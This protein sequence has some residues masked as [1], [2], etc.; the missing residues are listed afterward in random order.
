MLYEVAV[1]ALGNVAKHAR[2]T[3]VRVAVSRAGAGWV[4]EVVDDGVGTEVDEH[5]SA[6]FGLRAMRQRAV[7]AGGTLEVDSAPGRGT[8]VRL[9]VPDVA[10][11]GD[12]DRGGWAADPRGPLEH[13]LQNVSDAFVAL[14]TS[15]RYVYVN[16]AAAALFCTTPDRMLGEELWT[17]FP[18][19]EGSVFDEAYRTAA[20]EQ[21]ALDI[22]EYFAPAD[23]WFRNRVL[24]S[25]GGLTVFI[26]DV[27]ERR[28]LQNLQDDTDTGSLLAHTWFVALASDADAGRAV[29]AG[30]EALVAPRP[31]PRA[32]GERPRPGGRG[33]RRRRRG[34]RPARLVGGHEVGRLRVT[35][36][37]G[38]SPWTGELA[39][40]LAQALAARLAPG[41][42]AAP[43][44][45][46]SGR[47]SRFL[48]WGRGRPVDVPTPAG[49]DPGVARASTGSATPTAGWSTSARPRACASGCRRTSR[50]SSALHPRTQQM[51][52]TA[53]S[54]EW[55][56]VGNEVEALQLE[57]AWIKEF[58]PRFNVKY[59]DDKSYPYLAVTMGE[60]YPRVQVMRGAKRKGTRYF[61]PYSH[62]W[63]IRETVDQMLR[64]FP[65]RT[66]SAGVF[67]APTRSAGRACSG[68]IGK[69]SAPCVDRVSRRSTASWPRTSATSWPATPT[70]SSARL[71][72]EMRAAAAELDF[73]RAA[74]LR[75]DIGALERALAKN[76]VVLGDAT[77]ADVFALA[78]D[79]LEAAVQVFH[80]RGGRIR[81][82]RGWVVEKVEDLDT[83]GPGRAPAPAGLRRARPATPCRARCW[84]PSCPADADDIA[85]WL[86]EPARL[87]G[88]PAGARSAA[89]S[90]HL[91]E[92]VARNAGQSLTRHK[93]QRA[94]DLTARSQALEELQQA[95]DLTEAPLRIE[96]YDVSHHQGAE[97]VASMVVFEDGLPRKSEYRRFAIKGVDGNDDTAAMHEV[98]HP[99]VP[100]LPR[101]APTWPSPS[102]ATTARTTCD[103]APTG[104]R[105]PARRV[106]PDTGR[107]ASSP[108]RRSSSWSTAAR[109]R[110][111]RRPGRWPSSASTTSR[112]RAGQAAGG[113]LAAG[114][115]AP[116][117]PAAHQRGPLPAAAGPRRGAPLRHHLPPPAPVQD[118]DRQRAGRR[119]G[120]GQ[121]RR[122]ALL[123]HFG[124][125]KRVR[126]ADVEEIAA[127]ARHRGA[128]RPRWSSQH[129]A[130][131]TAQRTPAVNI[132]TGEIL[133]DEP[134]AADRST[135]GRRGWETG[136]VTAPEP[137]PSDR[138]ERTPTARPSSP[139]VLILTGMSGAGRSTTANALEDLGWYV[140]DNLPPQMLAPMAD[141]AER[142]PRRR[143][144]AGRRRRRP[145]P[146][147]LRRPARRPGRRCASSGCAPGWCSSTPPTTCWSAGSSRSAG[148]TRCR[149]RAGSWTASRAERELLGELRGRG[150]HRDRHLAPQRAPALGQGHPGCSTSDGPSHG[151][152]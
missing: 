121:T 40:M 42:P 138:R 24:P 36:P 27:T 46:V 23:R 88:R 51:V 2:A 86:G 93:L 81:G 28:R 72:Q 38:A 75:D 48:G 25:P 91:M 33:R 99:P 68:Y 20:R 69:C 59:R 137:E 14:D 105:Q 125:L 74:R 44:G 26:E 43:A 41:P 101:G 119:P 108:T 31:A 6:G 21:R 76:A 131:D 80:V 96:C 95:L 100:P 53:A 62:A 141:L 63:A 149:A 132:T 98:H 87:A 16:R 71:E 56:V 148:R 127:G 113:G 66:C 123:R 15:W 18:A 50:T 104:R 70:A 89:T 147:L 92:T 9:R 150:R 84:C 65:V 130:G 55:T 134:A 3:T 29:R 39:V 52:T 136:A 61:G 126:Q 60:D 83:A 67:R 146:D 94:G 128:P 102:S 34:R 8:T 103:R 73:E 13:I 57:Y 37:D 47:R 124:S 106:D 145:Q 54:V 122:T 7:A 1:E 19:G 11:F 117:R 114:R 140:V 64:V 144:P 4:L 135:R 151:C 79:E 115:G 49:G 5:A 10:T 133:D 109:R 45:T 143:C 85:A 111:P 30:A 152:G 90:G 139:E 118:D 32:A 22:E 35:W 17:L 116:G 120:L 129:L 82:Q 97:T 107:R 78:E 12:H 77:D 110:S 112:W 58:D 142:S